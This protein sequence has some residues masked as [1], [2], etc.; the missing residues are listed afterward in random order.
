MSSKDLIAVFVALTILLVGATVSIVYFAD[1]I[2]YGET[3]DR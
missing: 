3:N 1:E 2:E